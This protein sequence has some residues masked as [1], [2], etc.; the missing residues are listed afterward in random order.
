[1]D[2]T[3][4][5]DRVV[6][7]SFQ[8]GIG[9]GLDSDYETDPDTSSKLVGVDSTKSS[10]ESSNSIGG[11]VVFVFPCVGG[12]EAGGS[13]VSYCGVDGGVGH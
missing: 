3:L 2:L 7:G 4:I 8:T 5:V 1:M 13:G 6:T 9:V 12:L 11:R 10:S